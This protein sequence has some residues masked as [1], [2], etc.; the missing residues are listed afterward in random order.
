M[1][2]T[3]LNEL[4]QPGD[5]ILSMPTKRGMRSAKLWRRIKY[6]VTFFFIRMV[7]A[8]RWIHVSH[9]DR[10]KKGL[11]FFSTEPPK[12][13]DLTFEDYMDADIL[14][15]RRV[16][17]DTKQLWPWTAGQQKKARDE[18]KKKYR[19]KSYDIPQLPAMLG[20]WLLG[21]KR[22]KMY[23]DLQP[24]RFVCSTSTAGLERATGVNTFGKIHEGRINPGDIL[25]NKS[26]MKACRIKNG[27]LIFMD[28][29]AYR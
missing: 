5:W 19:G 9:A 13:K 3:L 18:W 27:K 21:I 25:R 28:A 10:T 7:S 22:S 4:I 11:V 16:R 17:P 1:N 26:R 2:K 23:F 14:V 20:N 29:R 6:S 15:M 8:C 12:A 24:N